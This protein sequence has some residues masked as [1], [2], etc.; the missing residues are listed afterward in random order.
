[1]TDSNTVHGKRSQR[2][3]MHE[4]IEV[5]YENGVFRPLTPLPTRIREHARLTVIIE[6]SSG[7]ALPAGRPGLADEIRRQSL[8]ASRSA[9]DGDALTFIDN[10]AVTGDD[11]D[12]RRG[13]QLQGKLWI[14]P[15][16][17]APDP[18]IAHLFDG[19]GGPDTGGKT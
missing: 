4:Q 12:S 18:E 6:T 15:D 7:D 19:G 17:D 10:A 5:I 2:Q 11:V 14:A 8:V 3:T 16:F 1:M 13:G 9:G